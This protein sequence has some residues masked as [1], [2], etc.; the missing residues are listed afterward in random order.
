MPDRAPARIDEIDATVRRLRHELG[1]L[2]R[3]GLET[4]I[5]RCHQQLRFW[6]FL[7]GI[8]AL[9]PLDRRA[10]RRS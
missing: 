7:A 10:E 2:E 5:A 9:S 4:P 1:R 8:H 3:L 6:E